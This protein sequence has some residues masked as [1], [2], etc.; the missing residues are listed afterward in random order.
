[1]EV[2]I[3]AY[4]L[5]IGCHPDM[6]MKD[7][8]Q[9]PL[10][11][12]TTV[13]AFLSTTSVGNICKVWALCVGF[14]GFFGVSLA[15]VNASCELELKMLLFLLYSIPC[16]TGKHR[17]QM[18]CCLCRFGPDHIFYGRDSLAPRFVTTWGDHSTVEV[19]FYLPFPCL[20]CTEIVWLL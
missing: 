6:S 9:A 15:E 7:V 2:L 8:E 20:T 5:K 19:D 4:N 14:P 17:L 10:V 1:M 12:D 13:D 3:L 16:L 18:H 11:L